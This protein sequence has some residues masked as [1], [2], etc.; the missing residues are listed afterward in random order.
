MCNVPIHRQFS[1]HKGLQE[2][3]KRLG[4]GPGKVQGSSIRGAH[5]RQFQ[6]PCKASELVPQKHELDLSHMSQGSVQ[7]SP[8]RFPHFLVG[9]H[10]HEIITAKSEENVLCH[11]NTTIYTKTQGWALEGKWLITA[12][13]I[14]RSCFCHYPLYFSP[15]ITVQCKTCAL[16]RTWDTSFYRWGEMTSREKAWTMGRDDPS[17]IHVGVMLGLWE[18]KTPCFVTCCRM[19]WHLGPPGKMKTPKEQAS[20]LKHISL[21]QII[22]KGG[23]LIWK[24]NNTM[25]S[26]TSSL[27]LLNM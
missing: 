27:L 22:R 10:P 15:G 18:E 8:V 17:S 19:S 13:D 26:S 7:Q 9:R 12:H 11:G 3:G 5:Q 4:I 1:G 20:F 2:Q 16:G 6:K 23:F 14:H 21:T 24:P 25:S